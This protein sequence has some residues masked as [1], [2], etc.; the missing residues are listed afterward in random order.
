MDSEVSIT[1]APVPGSSAYKKARRQFAKSTRNRPSDD[2]FGWTPSALQRRDIKPN[3]INCCIWKG[4]PD[5]FDVRE[6]EIKTTSGLGR[7]RVKAFCIPQVPGLVLLP[8][9][10]PPETQRNLV[11]WS[12]SGHARWPNQTNL[13]IH[14][15]VPEE[16]VW[17]LHT[18][19]QADPQNLEAILI[20]PKESDPAAVP[21][22]PGPRQL[23]SNTPASLQNFSD[24]S[25]Q[26]K[27][28][29]APSG[30]LKPATASELLPRLRWANIGWFYHW[31][32]KQ[33]DFSRGKAEVSEPLRSICKEMVGSINWEDVFGRDLETQRQLDWGET[34]PDWRSW[35]STYGEN[36]PCTDYMIEVSLF[37][38]T[39]MA[40]VDRSEMCATSPLVSLS[41]GNAAV[42]LIGGLTRD[43]KPVPILLRSGDAVV[44]AGPGCRRAYHGVPRI[45]EGTLPRHLQPSE[46]RDPDWNAF[47][48]YLQTARININAR[49]VFPKGFDPLESRHAGL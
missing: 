30:H 22:P 38:D 8:G 1:N 16:G 43:E 40:H 13:D 29:S 3:E 26:P 28:P 27:P 36:P 35:K 46:V 45:L 5:A 33:Y 17:N 6:V 47:G 18:N 25:N 44:M 19:S 14:Y 39:L 2:S 11:R 7:R 34:G 49:Q 21:E 37:Q 20:S 10:L 42:F 31:G 23:V 32:T 9:F 4:R 41:L 12:L 24:L 48:Q 15:N